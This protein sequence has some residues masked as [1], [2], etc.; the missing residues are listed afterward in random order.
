MSLTVEQI[1]TLT[2]LVET[3]NQTINEL[4]AIT[5][6][7]QSYLQVADQVMDDPGHAIVMEL[8]QGV[9]NAITALTT[10]LP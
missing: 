1:K 7:A 3:C 2:T 4:H 5:T 6:K 9:T 8:T 10:L